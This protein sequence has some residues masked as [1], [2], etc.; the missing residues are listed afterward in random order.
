MLTYFLLCSLTLRTRRR[1][2]QSRVSA[3]AGSDMR[4]VRPANT[5]FLPS[6]SSRGKRTLDQPSRDDV[7][8]FD[9]V[10]IA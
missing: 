6:L 7:E 1:E 10:Q 5:L 2:C 9:T 4:S 3:N 8:V